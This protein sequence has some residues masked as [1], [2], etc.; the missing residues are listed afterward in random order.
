MTKES[1]SI[2]RVFKLFISALRG[3]ETEFTTGSINKAIVLL[4]IPIIAEMTGEALFALIDMIFVSRVSVNAVAT[5]GLTEAPLMIIFSLAIG[6]SMAAT[7]IVAR[8]VGEKEYER[9]ANAAFQAILIAIVIGIVLGFFGYIYSAE[10]LSLMGGDKSLIK[11][12]VGY[13][14]VMYGGNISIVLIFL[15][16]GIFRGAGNASIAMKSLLLANGL[17]IILDPIFI[18]GWGFIPAYGVEGAAIATTIGR[19]CGVV[20]QVFYL[21]NGKSLI[22]IGVA[23]FVVKWKTIKEIIVISAGGI[24][25]FLVETLS[26]LFLVRIV[27]EFGKEA[28]AGY[29]IAFRVIYFTL[30]PSWGMANAAATLVGQ[31]LGALKPD[32]AE[33]SVWVT[34]K[35]NAMFLI[36]ITVLFSLF[37]TE[38]LSI[39][40]QPK[41]VID[42]GSDALKIICVGYVFFAYGMVAGQ[43]FNGAGDTKT[44]MYISI[45]VFWLIQIPLSYFLSFNMGWETNGVFFCIAFCHSLY[46][47]VAI[48]IFKRGNWKTVKV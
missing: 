24:G 28:M 34:A 31:N 37:S 46:A 38:V 16:N 18:F 7:A 20:Y 3:K 26:W 22:K 2:T 45:V 10:I 25:Q 5:I 43:G 35:W 9:A 14:Q 1:F 4:S 42:I 11:E 12:G 30:L 29:Q 32:R 19:S 33:K 44:P 21:F 41:A 15:I 27:S 36:L 48:A 13:T 6:L 23:N 47:L 39:F 40:D 17:N 8:R